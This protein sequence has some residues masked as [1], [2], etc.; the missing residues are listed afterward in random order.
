MESAILIVLQYVQTSLPLIG[1]NSSAINQILTMLI[2]LMPIIVN[3]GPVV[4]NS[5]NN[6]ITALQSSSDLTDDQISTLAAL[7]AEL[8]TAY[9][10]SV[11]AYLASKKVTPAATA[12]TTTD[13]TEPAAEEPVATQVTASPVS[14]PA[15]AIDGAV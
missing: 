3:L 11:M 6:I 9:E 2:S 8:D 5:A 15:V 7:S 4:I 1:V 12:S 14:V 10:A 13:T